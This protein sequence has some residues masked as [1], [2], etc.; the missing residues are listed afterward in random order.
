MIETSADPRLAA[1]LA[2]VDVPSSV[3]AYRAQGEALWVSGLLGPELLAP[4]LD[5]LERVRPLVHRNYV[6]MQK[7]GGSVSYFQLREQAPHLVALYRDPALIRFLEQITGER[8]MPCPEDDPHACAL[9]FYTEEGDHI[10]WHFDT[11]F[12]KGKRFTVLIGLVDRSSSRLLCRLHKNTPGQVPRDVELATLPGMLVAFNG[13]SLWHAVSPLGA[14]EE[15][16][17]LSLEYVTNQSMSPWGRL[18][19]NIK[20]AIAYFGIRGI[21]RPRA[22]AAGAGR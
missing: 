10:G 19:S 22:S 21:F 5:D 14:G 7:K 11:S 20:D 17:S 13:D 1:A 12:Y 2:N 15:R 6:P 3:E 18:I 9:Y 4:L 8:L 16:I